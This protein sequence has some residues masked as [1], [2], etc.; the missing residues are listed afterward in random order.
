MTQSVKFCVILAGCW[1]S[2]LFQQDPLTLPIKY[3][4]IGWH[5]QWQHVHCPHTK[6]TRNITSTHTNDPTLEGRH[7]LKQQ[8]V[9]KNFI[10]FLTTRNQ[11]GMR[12]R[13]W[14]M[15]LRLVQKTWSHFC[16]VSQSVCATC[17]HSLPCHLSEGHYASRFWFLFSKCL[18]H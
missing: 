10:H 15:P 2:F 1:I 18:Q 6:C 7:S 14:W 12:N 17:C 11:I 8:R 3:M 16:T 5:C 13:H 4:H 9:N